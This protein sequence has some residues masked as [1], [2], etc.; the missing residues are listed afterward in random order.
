[1]KNHWLEKRIKEKMSVD[2]QIAN[3]ITDLYFIVEDQD[4]G[5]VQGDFKP[6]YDKYPKVRIGIRRALFYVDS[7]RRALRSINA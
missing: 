6:L 3:F 5:S 4:I 1:M 2:E 7:V